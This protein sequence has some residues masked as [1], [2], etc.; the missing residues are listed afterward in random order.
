MS[1]VP[2][3]LSNQPVGSDYSTTNHSNSK[4]TSGGNNP[5]FDF[6]ASMDALADKKTDILRS[7]ADK[8]SDYAIKLNNAGETDIKSIYK[9]ITTSLNG[10]TEDEKNQILTMAL[11]KII[12]NI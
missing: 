7:A 4:K 11:A 10:F 3:F 8:V 6:K 12:A 5:W 1:R 2:S 9:N